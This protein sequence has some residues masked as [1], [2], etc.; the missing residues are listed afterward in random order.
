MAR[1]LFTVVLILTLC[2]NCGKV[3]GLKRRIK[4]TKCKYT[5]VVNEMDTANCPSALSQVQADK[6]PEKSFR[7]NPLLPLNVPTTATVENSNELKTWLNNM[8]KQLYSELKKSDIINTTLS[9]HEQSLSKAEQ[10]LRDYETNF[11]T[12]FRMLRYLESSIQDQNKMSKNLDKKLS[13]VM[14]DVVEV[15]NV[16]SKKVTAVGDGQIHAKEIDVQSVSKVTSCSLSPETV[17]YR[18]CTDV[19]KRHKESG[20]YY[21][22]PTYAPCPIP[23]WCDMDTTLGG[24][25]IIMKRQ[26]G[27]VDFK[28]L[29]DDY[30]HGFGNIVNEYYLGNDNIFL[31][32]NQKHYELRIDLWDF[33]GNR[34]YALYKIF[35]IDGERDNYRL[36][37]HAYEGSAKD[38]MKSHDRVMFSTP[39]RDNDQRQGYNC[40]KEWMGGWWFNNC[41]YSYL[42]GTYYN[43]SNVRYRGISWNDWKHEQLARVEM[44]IRPSRIAPSH[45]EYQRKNDADDTDNTQKEKKR[46]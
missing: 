2:L 28:R 25:L 11:T 6:E 32:S 1:K 15:N 7:V 38:S 23:V 22:T 44:K 45:F 43:I 37:I 5:F 34:V 13:G 31:L 30:K 39:D 18:D 14:L 17:M 36:Y 12:I 26:N 8:E 33:S 3:T 46:Y 41:W 10:V 19:F 20:V 24:W 29:W 16:L 27:E 4:T 21:I 9:K 42:T 40:A 35:R